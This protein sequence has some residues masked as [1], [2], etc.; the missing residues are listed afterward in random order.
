ISVTDAAGHPETTG[1][2]QR[3]PSNPDTLVVPLRPHLPEGW[4]LVYWRAISVDGHPVQSA[5]TFAIGPTPGPAPQFVIPHISGSATTPRLVILRWLTL[6]TVM[7]ALGLFVLRIAIARPVVRRVEGTTLRKVSIAFVVASVLGLIAIPVYID[8]STAVDSLRSSFAVGALVPLFR[9]TAFGR[10]YVD[11]E[12]CFAL[13][14]LAAWVALWLD[15]PERELRSIAELLATGGAL[16]A[17]AAVCLIPGIAGHAAQTSPRG[18][19]LLVDWVH[20]GAGALWIGGLIG[21]LVLWRSLPAIRR[22]E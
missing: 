11:L 3:S 7:A 18:A 10:A 20:V 22:S 8:V 2:V 5:F 6:L 16:V 15:R 1:P 12:I 9:V 21:L 13:F 14:C 17:A 4:Y 19:A